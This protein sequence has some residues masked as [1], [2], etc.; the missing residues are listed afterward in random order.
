C[1]YHFIILLNRLTILIEVNNYIKSIILTLLFSGMAFGAHYLLSKG[2]GVY[3]SWAATEYSLEG[4]YTFMAIG[5]LAIVVVFLLANWSM[6]KHMSFIYLGATLMEGS[7]SYMYIQDGL[8]IR[9]N[10]F[11]AFQSVVAF[12][13]F[14]FSAAYMA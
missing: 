4:L 7:A 10:K 2:L 11:I 8:G 9:E 13:S 6:P 1:W 5:T 12:F 3:A 14:L